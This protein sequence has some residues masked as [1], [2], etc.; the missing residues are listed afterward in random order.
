ML[1]WTISIKINEES[2]TEE[3]RRISILKNRLEY[4]MMHMEMISMEVQRDEKSNDNNW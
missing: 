4:G 3:M 1:L 2:K